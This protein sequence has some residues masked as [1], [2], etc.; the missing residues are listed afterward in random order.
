M[1]LA[2][3]TRCHDSDVIGLASVGGGRLWS[4]RFGGD[5]G[6][7]VS[8]AWGRELFGSEET[9]KPELFTRPDST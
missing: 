6:N 4:G 7:V 2:P 8:S 5:G 3:V 1:S 9:V